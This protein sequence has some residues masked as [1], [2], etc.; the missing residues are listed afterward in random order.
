MYTN[1]GISYDVSGHFFCRSAQQP[2]WTYLV[3]S[4]PDGAAGEGEPLTVRGYVHHAILHGS[5]H[6]LT[7]TVYTIYMIVRTKCSQT[8]TLV[9][10][11]I[12]AEPLYYSGSVV[13]QVTVPVPTFDKLQ[14]RFRLLYQ[15]R[16]KV[17]KFFLEKIVPFYIL[18]FF[19]GKIF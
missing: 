4:Y 10:K 17:F 16:S 1:I 5:H 18:S 7:C 19:Q 9:T 3:V 8:L 15:Q 13:W 6:T 14:F 12:V 2:V 11:A